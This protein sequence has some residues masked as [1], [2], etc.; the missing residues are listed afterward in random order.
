M[1]GGAPAASKSGRGES[2]RAN[3]S[4]ETSRVA[5]RVRIRPMC[6][7]GG[8]PGALQQ[9]RSF[10]AQA[11]QR[12]QVAYEAR[13]EIGADALPLELGQPIDCF[14]ATVENPNGIVGHASQGFQAGRLLAVRD[15]TQDEGGI[16][17]GFQGDVMRTRPDACGEH[18]V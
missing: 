3:P 1:A 16:N 14:R 8:G 13:I 17:A 5:T 6:S 9:R 2:S 18:A 7:D 11:V 10:G 15:A 12:Q 4:T